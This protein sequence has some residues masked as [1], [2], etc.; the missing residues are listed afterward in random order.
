MIRKLVIFTIALI[1]SSH[2]SLTREDFKEE[3]KYQTYKSQR[4]NEKKLAHF[5]TSYWHVHLP[6]YNEIVEI[7][8]KFAPQDRK[9]IAHRENFLEKGIQKLRDDKEELERKHHLIFE[10]IQKKQ[11]R[12]MLN[13]IN[14]VLNNRTLNENFD[15]GLYQYLIV[16]LQQHLRGVQKLDAVDFIGDHENVQKRVLIQ[17]INESFLYM[18]DHIFNDLQ[19]IDYVQS[20]QNFKDS[21][22][23]LNNNPLIHQKI[24]AV[25]SRGAQMGDLTSRFDDNPDMTTDQTFPLRAKTTLGIVW[26]SIDRIVPMQERENAK[27]SFALGVADC[28]EADGHRVCPIGIRSRLIES[29][30]HYVS[31][32]HRKHIKYTNKETPLED[33]DLQAFHTAFLQINLYEIYKE[34]KNPV[35]RLLFDDYGDDEIDQLLTIKKIDFME[36]IHHQYID[37]FK[38]QLLEKITESN[39][40]N[41]TEAQEEHYI[42]KFKYERELIIDHTL[43]EWIKLL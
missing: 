22:R 35:V 24:E 5:Q 36:F 16:D 30:E 40:I 3:Q 11:K 9:K 1:H 38:Q 20:Y 34:E 17:N 41:L 28:I 23:L 27:K 14:E 8:R 15:E 39:K 26:A 31:D 42:N 10:Q 13:C 37:E 18:R 29:I 2:A 32:Q 33:F 4:A 7:N 21:F 6:F 12:K 25:L 19:P 43:R